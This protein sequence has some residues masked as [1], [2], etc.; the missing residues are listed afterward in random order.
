MQKREYVRCEGMDEDDVGRKGREILLQQLFIFRPRAG[1]K[2]VTGMAGA[3]DYDNSVY[4]S[5]KTCIAHS[6]SRTLWC[7]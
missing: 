6:F 5:N 3:I 7:L 1:V 2:V 4:Q